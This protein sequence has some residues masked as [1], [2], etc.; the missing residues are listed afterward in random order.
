MNERRS[1]RRSLEF[2]ERKK[3]N[4]KE[5]RVNGSHDGHCEH[6]GKSWNECNKKM[7]VV[8]DVKER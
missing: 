8:P 7:K 3:K 6:C 5:A 2:Y 1:T 4:A